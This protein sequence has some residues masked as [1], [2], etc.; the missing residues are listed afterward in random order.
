MTILI[1]HFKLGRDTMNIDP[2]LTFNLAETL[3]TMTHTLPWT[4]P[5][6]SERQYSYLTLNLAETLWTL[7]HASPLS[8]PRRSER[9]PMPHLYLGRDAINDDPYLTSNS[10]ETLWTTIFI[11]Y[12]ELGRDAINADPCLTFSSAETLLTMAHASPST[13]PRCN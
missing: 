4:Q 12:F 8:R 2:C 9:W 10:A 3:L 11:P 1:P 5:R 6:R 7:T 13:R